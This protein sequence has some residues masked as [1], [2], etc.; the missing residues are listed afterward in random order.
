MED[1]A[2]MV[3]AVGV[4]AKFIQHFLRLRLR[5]VAAITSSVEKTG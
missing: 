5:R 1:E 2:G 4:P 3:G